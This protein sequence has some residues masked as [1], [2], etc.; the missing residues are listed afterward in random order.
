MY[1]QIFQSSKC[2]GPTL[3][4]LTCHIKVTKSDLRQL[5]CGYPTLTDPEHTMRQAMTT[6][7]LRCVSITICADSTPLY[8]IHKTLSFILIPRSP[9]LCSRH[10]NCIDFAAVR[11]KSG[12]C[13]GISQA[14]LPRSPETYILHLICKA[15]TSRPPAYWV[16]ITKQRKS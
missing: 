6:A 7:D 11:R 5:E 13:V 2:H 1:L 12:C 4:E 14:R 16:R 9:R 3:C 15:E 8:G 10:R